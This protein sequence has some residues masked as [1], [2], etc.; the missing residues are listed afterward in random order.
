MPF[1]KCYYHV[2]WATHHRQPLLTPEIGAAVADTV[3][4]KSTD[5]GC[6]ILALNHVADHLHVAVMIRPALAPASWVQQVKGLSAHEVNASFPNL[7]DIFRWQSGYGLLSFG[8]RNLPMVIEYIDRQ[9]EHHRT[10]TI[11]TYLECIGDDSD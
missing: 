10:N 9:P 4:R 8:E 5:L 1:W 3:W 11:E 2:I 7:P 6:E